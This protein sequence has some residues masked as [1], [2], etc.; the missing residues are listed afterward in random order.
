MREFLNRFYST[1]YQ[2]RNKIKKIVFSN[3]LVIISSWFILFLHEMK[4]NERS[5]KILKSN[6]LPFSTIHVLHYQR[7]SIKYA[8]STSRDVTVAWMN[9]T[10]VSDIK[11]FLNEYRN[12]IHSQRTQQICFYNE[13]CQYGSF[14]RWMSS[15]IHKLD[16][17][18]WITWRQ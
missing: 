8:F 9:I 2:M 12:N 4:W 13:I 11:T 7:V 16:S 1:H 18:Q 17:T 10:D 14:T 15:V 6:V 3:F 5:L